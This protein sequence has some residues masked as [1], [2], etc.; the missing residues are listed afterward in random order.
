M[1]PQTGSMR[2]SGSMSDDVVTRMKNIDMVELG[3][4]VMMA[5]WKCHC[6]IP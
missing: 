6:G 2:H 1:P 5:L 4:Y 3:R